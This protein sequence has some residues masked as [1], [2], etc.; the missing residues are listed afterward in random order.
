M[1]SCRSPPSWSN[2]QSWDRRRFGLSYTLTSRAASS[3]AAA[4]SAKRR[5]ITQCV[6]RRPRRTADW[7]L[8][9][10]RRR[11]DLVR[12]HARL[13][14]QRFRRHRDRPAGSVHDNQAGC[15]RFSCF[16]GDAD[17]IP[18]NHACVFAT[19]GAAALHQRALRRIRL[20]AQLATS[21]DRTYPRAGSSPTTRWAPSATCSAHTN[22]RTCAYACANTPRLACG[23]SG[24]PYHLSSGEATMKGDC[25]DG[26]S[27]RPQTIPAC[28][29]SRAVSAPM[30]TTMMR[31]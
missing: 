3:T 22:G 12:P 20:R 31:C 6:R 11:H 17:R 4:A 24:F 7:G 25:R 14:G 27:I 8:R 18:P 13:Q 10:D 5:A 28:C 30:S 2:A 23:R 16:S 21:S 1:P 29:I 9:T 26:I 15:I 19:S